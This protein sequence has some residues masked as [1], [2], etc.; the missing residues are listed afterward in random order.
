MSNQGLPYVTV[1][2]GGVL[3][4]FRWREYF[5]I[6]LRLVV[7]V[8]KT[9]IFIAPRGALARHFQYSVD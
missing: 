5:V 9:G 4:V 7:A 8:G 6:N 2:T 3:W 1:W